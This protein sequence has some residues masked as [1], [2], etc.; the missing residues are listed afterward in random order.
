VTGLD[1]GRRLAPAGAGAL[2][3][4]ALVLA[5]AVGLFAFT[6]IGLQTH[7]TPRTAGAVLATFLPL[8]G[9]WLAVAAWRGSYRHRSRAALLVTWILG[10]PA[11]LLLRQVVLG[12][13][14]SPGFAV[15]LAV[16][17]VMTMACVLAARAA[18]WGG[19]RLRGY[20]SSA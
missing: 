4:G 14:L 19:W 7:Q 5:D 16:A 9:A 15:F 20:G 8:L 6:W 13:G 3:A 2:P 10:V 11:G 17:L 12:R 1:T 18:A